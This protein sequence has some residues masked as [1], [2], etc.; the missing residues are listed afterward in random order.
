M[1]MVASKPITIKEI[2][3]AVK[4][5][6]AQYTVTLKRNKFLKFNYAEVKK[7]S[8]IGNRIRV[9]DNNITVVGAI[10]STFIRA[11]FGGLIFIAFIPGKLKKL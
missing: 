5:K 3:E 8:T 9:E 10:P 2:F 11:M 4:S 6:F 1:N 7:N